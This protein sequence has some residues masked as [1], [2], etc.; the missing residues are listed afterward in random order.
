MTEGENVEVPAAETAANAQGEQNEAQD[1]VE[2]TEA[3]NENP[4]PASEQNET[5]Q[6]QNNDQPEVAQSNDQEKTENNENN[7]VTENQTP[8]ESEQHHEE[9]AAEQKEPENIEV[10]QEEHKDQPNDQPVEVSQEQNT[11]TQQN[12]EPNT[13]NQQEEKQAENNAEN[14]V[15]EAKVEAREITPE[16][17]TAPKSEETEATEAKNENE[18]QNVEKQ[19]E[20]QE[21][22]QPKPEENA[23]NTENAENAS[24]E[25]KSDDEYEYYEEEEDEKDASAKNRD[26]KTGNSADPEKQ[27]PLSSI[28]TNGLTKPQEEADKPKQE[29]EES[30]DKAQQ[31][32][33]GPL[34]SIITDALQKP[35]ENGPELKENQ[36]GNDEQKENPSN[37]QE[38]ANQDKEVPIVAVDNKEDPQEIH[39]SVGVHEPEE[40][41]NNDENEEE[42][43]IRSPRG[44]STQRSRRPIPP[45][46]ADPFAFRRSMPVFKAPEVSKQALEI[47]AKAL[48]LETLPVVPDEIYTQAIYSLSEDRKAKIQ[49]HKFKEGATVNKVILHIQDMQLKQRKINAQQ[50]AQNS[51]KEQ[52]DELKKLLDDFD[53]ETKKQT[54]ELEDKIQDQRNQLVEKHEKELDDHEK[55]W[56]SDQM[57]KM[58][59]HVSSSISTMRAQMKSLLL[60]CR[61]E[62][63]GAIEVIA[64][65]QKAKEEMMNHEVMQTRFNES[66]K[67]LM[68]RQSDELNTFDAASKVKVQNFQNKRARERLPLENKLHKVENI[69]NI[70]NDKER[71]WNREK[72]RRAN[73]IAQTMTRSTTLTPSNRITP[74]DLEESKFELLSLPPLKSNRKKPKQK[75][76]KAKATSE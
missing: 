69:K 66:Q 75:A 7:N 51:T 15:E 11:E 57:M 10:T 5:A 33:S 59:N 3:V 68:Q 76:A 50:S 41:A 38:E 61:F 26:L 48:K 58:F 18:N 60:Q 24:K 71:L 19:Q 54:K 1:Q 22:E 13:E 43:P 30:N 49:D 73:E 31:E 63:A 65:E 6:D 35:D 46:T 29:G 62:E 45:R 9:N 47:K 39:I 21:K 2:Q 42:S 53:K 34:S 17:E 37:G 55:L 23:N 56:N 25:K 32:K 14:P 8:Q 64:N 20:D 67:L 27:G 44:S 70:V 72:L 36:Q 52:E 4:P 74:R 16:G 12:Q 40:P 28:I